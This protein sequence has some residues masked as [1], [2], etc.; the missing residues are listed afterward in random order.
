[1]AK[2]VVIQENPERTATILDDSVLSDYNESILQY[3]ERFSQVLGK[4]RQSDLELTGS[5]PFMLVHLANSGLLPEDSQLAIRQVLETA[6][7]KD[8]TFLSGQYTYFG[9]SLRTPRDSYTE[10]DLSAKVLAKDLSK[11][12]IKLGKGKLIPFN[13]LKNEE[14]S[15]S[16]YGAVFRLKEQANTDDILDLEQFKWDYS[17]REGLACAYLGRNRSWNSSDRSLADSIGFGRVVVVSGEATSKKILDR[18]L[19]EF[20][21]ERDREIEQLKRNFDEREKNLRV[22]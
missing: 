4:F 12:E 2:Q 15:D 5:S 10:N 6:I 1:M 3:G 20:R 21:V 16:H 17:R 14:N 18:Y 19:S 11:R 9:L 13:A 8:N 22:K 7:S